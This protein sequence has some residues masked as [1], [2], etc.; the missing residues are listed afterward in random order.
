[1]K[2]IILAL[3]LLTCSCYAV[4]LDRTIVL[5]NGL[6]FDIKPKYANNQL[7]VDLAVSNGF[8]RLQDGENY[9]IHPVDS[10]GSDVASIEFFNTD[11]S[12]NFDAYK[13][14]ALDLDS[15]NKII[16]F[17]MRYPSWVE[18]K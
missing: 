6:T 16:K 18:D 12:R 8:A 10:D 2:K 3:F 9:D 17:K 14:T 15:F 4:P 1:M 5:D 13:C 7:C 11:F